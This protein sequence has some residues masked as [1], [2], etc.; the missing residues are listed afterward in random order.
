MW[1]CIRSSSRE[2]KSTLTSLIFARP[3]RSAL[4]PAM[5]ARL[6]EL[7]NIDRQAHPHVEP[8]KG[9]REVFSVRRPE[10]FPIPQSPTIRLGEGHRQMEKGRSD[11]LKVSPG[12]APPAA[13]A[14]NG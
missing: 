7:R 2:L 10:P 6:L 5:Q 14:T 12:R 9:L 13:T 3:R 11:S 4:E 1:T 8:R